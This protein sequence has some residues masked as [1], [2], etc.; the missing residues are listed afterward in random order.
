MFVDALLVVG[1]VLFLQEFLQGGHETLGQV[2]IL[3]HHP[4]SSGTGRLDGLLC[5]HLLSLAQGDQEQFLV[6]DLLL[7]RQFYQLI[8][9]VR[10]WGQDEDQGSHL[11]QFPVHCVQTGHSHCQ[12]LPLL[13]FH[14]LVHALQSRLYLDYLDQQQLLEGR[15]LTL[16]LLGHLEAE[17]TLVLDPLA[18]FFAVLGNAIQQL[19]PDVVVCFEVLQSLYA[20][21]GYLELHR[22]QEHTGPLL[23]GR[24]TLRQRLLGG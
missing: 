4:A 20:A 9:R 23:G 19:L 7:L 14:I 10:P 6:L 8:H 2:A 15:D 18:P 1:V 12:L 11:F 21:V 16:H 3:E 5:H 24:R 22:G 13:S 17:W